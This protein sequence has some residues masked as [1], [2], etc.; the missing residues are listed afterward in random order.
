[1]ANFAIRNLPRLFTSSPVYG[2]MKTEDIFTFSGGKVLRFVSMLT[3]C[4]GGYY[5]TDR[6]G[7]Q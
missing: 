3:P 6:G 1:M 7:E 2:M 5:S 4:Q